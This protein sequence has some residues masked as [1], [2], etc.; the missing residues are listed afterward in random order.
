MQLNDPIAILQPGLPEKCEQ[1]ER[2]EPTPAMW[3]MKDRSEIRGGIFNSISSTGEYFCQQC[4][5]RADT[6]HQSRRNAH[7][8]GQQIF[9]ATCGSW[10]SWGYGAMATFAALVLYGIWEIF[11]DCGCW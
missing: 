2:D 3:F 10:E 9:E 8:H 7:P 11:A 6:V 4:C 1:C 5:P